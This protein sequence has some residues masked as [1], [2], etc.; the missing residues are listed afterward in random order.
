MSLVSRLNKLSAIRN[1]VWLAQRNAR[2]IST[3]PKKSDTATITTEKTEAVSSTKVENKN[4][5]SWGWDY[6]DEKTDRTEMNASFFFSVTLCLVFGTVYFA[7][8]P[9][10]FLRDWSQRE[11]FLVLRRREAAG[12]EPISA[13][14]IDPANIELPTEEELGEFEVVI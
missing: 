10:N 3:S 13:D 2:L 1:A 8:T 12:L 4:W 14:Y 11:A 9:D 7:Y 5:V 6:K